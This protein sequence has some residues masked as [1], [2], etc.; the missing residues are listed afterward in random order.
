M[1][2]QIILIAGL[3][4]CLL[5]AFVHRKSSR[6]V[7]VLMAVTSVAGMYFVL[8]PDQTTG[9]AHALGVGRGVDLVFYCWLIITLVVSLNLQFKIL[10]LQAAVTALTRELALRDARPSAAQSPAR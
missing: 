5:Y 4:A 3:L 2:I 8:L 10:G 1:I 9:I 7:T 6:L